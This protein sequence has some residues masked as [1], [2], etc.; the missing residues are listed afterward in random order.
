MQ[1]VV[2]PSG[3]GVGGACTELG[4]IPCLLRMPPLHANGRLKL[5]LQV[6][7]RTSGLPT[8]E[9][10]GAASSL[11][12]LHGRCRTVNGPRSGPGNPASGCHSVSFCDPPF[13]VTNRSI[14]KLAAKS[15]SATIRHD[16]LPIGLPH[17]EWRD[18]RQKCFPVQ[19]P[20]PRSESRPFS[21]S[22]THA[23][24]SLHD[25]TVGCPIIHSFLLGDSPVECM[26]TTLS[27]IQPGEGR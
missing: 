21:C 3:Y 13:L 24:I 27:I 1:N 22:I 11:T 7:D 4:T 10:I 17:R 5:W 20:P 19:N 2:G 14:E 12:T 6:P 26:H 25:K 18:L 23:F 9:S 15:A 8:A 16:G